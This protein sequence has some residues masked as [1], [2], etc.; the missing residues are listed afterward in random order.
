MKKISDC[1]HRAS[2]AANTANVQ[3]QQDFEY[4]LSTSL[5][6]WGK[7]DDV[8]LVALSLKM[9]LPV[10]TDRFPGLTTVNKSLQHVD[11]V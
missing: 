3:E 4:I 6:L 2:V 5:K 9:N 10:N 8:V 7:S 11:Q 1:Q